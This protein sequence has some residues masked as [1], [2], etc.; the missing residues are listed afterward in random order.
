MKKINVAILSQNKLVPSIELQPQ[1]IRVALKRKS[2]P[3][4]ER[5]AKINLMLSEL[6]AQYLKN[7]QI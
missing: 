5:L 3:I 4:N 1:R 6:K 2:K 7:T